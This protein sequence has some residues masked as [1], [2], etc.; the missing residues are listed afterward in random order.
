ML[1]PQATVTTT[2]SIHRKLKAKGGLPASADLS[3]CQT[4]IAKANLSSPWNR[5]VGGCSNDG[6]R[7]EGRGECSQV[8]RLQ[9]RGGTFVGRKVWDSDKTWEKAEG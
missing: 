7:D 9:S 5:R 3:Q 6:Q 4:G 8:V 1:S 2:V